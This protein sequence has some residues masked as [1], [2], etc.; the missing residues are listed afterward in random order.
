[1]SLCLGLS[2]PQHYFTTASGRI[3]T[4]LAIEPEGEPQPGREYLLMTEFFK[5]LLACLGES[6][7]LKD[8]VVVFTSA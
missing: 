8:C 1:M 2:T 4:R 7:A 5:S 3:A 6:I